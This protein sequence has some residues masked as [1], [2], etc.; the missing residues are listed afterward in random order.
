MKAILSVKKYLFIVLLIVSSSAIFSQGASISP[1]SNNPL[2]ACP[3]FVMSYDLSTSGI[4][5]KIQWSVTGGSISG[6]SNSNSVIVVWNNVQTV[7]NVIPSGTLKVDVEFNNQSVSA[8]YVQK[9]KSLNN[10]TLNPLYSDQ[11]DVINI[12]RKNVILNTASNYFPGYGVDHP[13]IKY[14]WTLPSGWTD[15]SGSSGTLITYSSQIKLVTDELTTGTVKVRGINDCSVVN[16]Y[17]NYAIKTITRKIS[18][19]NYPPYVTYGKKVSYNFSVEQLQDAIFEWKAPAGW[20]INGQGNILEGTNMNSVSIVQGN[21]LTDGVVSVRLKKNNKISEWF[22]CP[23]QGVRMPEIQSNVTSQ[24]QKGNLFLDVDSNEVESI[25]WTGDGLNIINGQGTL[26]P[27]VIISKAG[28]VKI[29]AVLKLRGCSDYN[30]ITKDFNISSPAFNI[31]GP[32]VVCSSARFTIDNIPSEISIEWSFASNKLLILSGQY[33]NSIYVNQNYVNSSY[34]DELIKA[35]LSFMGNSAYIYKST[36]IGS[37]YISSVSGPTN[38][39]VN[40]GISF[41]ADPIYTYDI[42]DYKWYVTPSTGVTQSPYR[43]TNYIIF[44]QPGYY[45]V[46]CRTSTTACGAAGSA[47]SINVSVGGYYMMYP[48]PTSGT[49]Y[50]TEKVVSENIS[51]GVTSLNIINVDYEVYSV[52]NNK[53]VLKGRLDLKSKLIDLN[54]LSNG[55]Y[56]LRIKTPNDMFESHKIIINK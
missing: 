39:I 22:V 52:T 17:T 49:I 11:G 35:K 40:Q 30:T 54:K 32:N 3:G 2:I 20:S 1:D 10:A 7:P 21:C 44:S 46:S 53:L 56:I 5:S 31:A 34:G 14:E 37:P 55:N 42:C 8:T 4:P 9:I 23:Y 47:A 41:T 13:I 33:T 27:E 25:V 38:A 51:E 26:S 6:A 50:V 45:T 18:F 16:D 19:T 36:F 48:N 29:N 43:H 15:A 28:L 24:F 12:G